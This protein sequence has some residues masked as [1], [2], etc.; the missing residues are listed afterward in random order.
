MDIF[1]RKGKLVLLIISTLFI[2]WIIYGFIRASQEAD[3]IKL[4]YRDVNPTSYVFPVPISVVRDSL[5]RLITKSDPVNF[6]DFIW[7]NSTDGESDFYLWPLGASGLGSYVYRY[8][9][10]EDHIN[11]GKEKY[12][13]HTFNVH[14]QAVSTDSTRVI[15]NIKNNSISYGVKFWTNVCFTNYV[16]KEKNVPSTTIEEYELLRYI[17][18]KLGYLKDMPYV[19]YPEQLTKEEILKTFGDNNPFTY[20]E[21]FE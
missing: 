7:E 10:R 21:M 13:Y 17:G 16:P 8:R 6:K 19:K 3:I 15:I 14:L 18:K 2:C 5:Q 4:E 1:N 20:Q 12:Q 9:T 11:A